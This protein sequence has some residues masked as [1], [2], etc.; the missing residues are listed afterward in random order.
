MKSVLFWDVMHRKVVI[1]YRL[2]EQG[3]FPIL[4]SQ[5]I[6]VGTVSCPV[7]S[8]R[9]GHSALRNIADERRSQIHYK[10]QLEQLS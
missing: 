10:L 2:F 1:S 7:M 3:V 6:F 9:T 8:V 5:K 4:M